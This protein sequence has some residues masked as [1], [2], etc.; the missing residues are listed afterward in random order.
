MRHGS[1][2]G[3]FSLR[4]C[5]REN[6]GSLTC[7]KLV[8]TLLHI[9]SPPSEVLVWLI[10]AR[11]G[12]DPLLYPKPSLQPTSLL[13]LPSSRNVTN[14]YTARTPTPLLVVNTTRMMRLARP[15]VARTALNHSR[16]RISPCTCTL[17]DRLLLRI[18]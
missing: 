11:L 3:T 8:S 6:Q 17:V 9:P 16:R 4:L 2:F 10:L 18:R 7:P 1:D 12:A 14:M 13:L 15:M 5:Y